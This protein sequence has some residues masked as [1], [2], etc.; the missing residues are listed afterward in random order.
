MK[1]EAN[2]RLLWQKG[3]RTRHTAE[4]NLHLNLADF[5]RS[6]DVR[7][8]LIANEGHIREELVRLLTNE[9]IPQMLRDSGENFNL[10]DDYTEHASDLKVENQA[11]VGIPRS[12]DRTP[13]VRNNIHML[14]NIDTSKSLNA[15]QAVYGIRGGVA[16]AIA[17]NVMNVLKGYFLNAHDHKYQSTAELSG[18]SLTGF[19]YRVKKSSADEN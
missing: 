14:L 10:P 2:S 6:R 19:E 4:L 9:I 18:D 15:L 16:T 13:I 1:Y 5:A 7:S 17:A 11:E 3:T 12:P 8:E